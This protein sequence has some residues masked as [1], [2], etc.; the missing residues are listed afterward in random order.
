MAVPSSGALSLLG[1]KRE[2]SND[3][4]SASNSHSNI[5]LKECS[6]GTVATINT[7]NSSSNRPNGSA[8]HSIS[9]FYVYDHDLSTLTE[10]TYNSEGQESAG[11]ACSL[12]SIEDTAYHDG[13]GTYPAVNDSVYSNSSGTTALSA[14]N[15]KIDNGSLNGA[16][17]EVT[18]SGE[19]RALA[20]CK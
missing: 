6:D 10:F 5:S 19:V 14:A 16:N 8:P 4:Y 2:L 13:S 1:I 12:E 17:M 11:N 20:N 18:S 15:Y 3:N 9:E 7:G